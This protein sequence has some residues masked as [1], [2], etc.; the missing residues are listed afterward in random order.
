MEEIVFLEPGVFYNPAGI[1]SSP[2]REE[3][4]LIW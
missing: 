3:R 1:T 4:Y 2:L